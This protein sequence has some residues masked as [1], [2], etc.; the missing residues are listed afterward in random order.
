MLLSVVKSTNPQQ[1]SGM[2]VVV[3]LSV[4]HNTQLIGKVRDKQCAM[5]IYQKGVTLLS[6]VAILFNVTHTRYVAAEEKNR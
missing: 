3:F 5:C 1:S 4:P 2:S 6:L